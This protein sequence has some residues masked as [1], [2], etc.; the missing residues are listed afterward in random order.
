MT[1]LPIDPSADA[2]LAAS[3]IPRPPLAVDRQWSWVRFDTADGLGRWMP[4]YRDGESWVSVGWRTPNV[5]EVGPV[6]HCGP[7]PDRDPI[8]TEALAKVAH[9]QAVIDVYKELF[10]ML[11]EKAPRLAEDLYRTVA[12][13]QGLMASGRTTPIELKP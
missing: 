7:S 3:G 5:L 12:E 2:K 4:A 9:Q 6:V 13:C 8:V 11:E 1:C 10:S